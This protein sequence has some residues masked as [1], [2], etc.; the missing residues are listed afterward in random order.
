MLKQIDIETLPTWSNKL[1]LKN[2]SDL[3]HNE[4]TYYMEHG[5]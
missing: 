1:K 2:F 5:T 4:V 3:G